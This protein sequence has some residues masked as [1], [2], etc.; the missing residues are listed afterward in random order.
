MVNTKITVDDLVVKIWDSA[1]GEGEPLISQE[2]NPD[3]SAWASREEARIWAENYVSVVLGLIAVEPVFPV[4]EEAPAE[5]P[6][7]EAPAEEAPV[8]EP[9]VVAPA[10]ETPA[11]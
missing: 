3:G 5:E 10:E 2:T 9:V 6:A 11:E 1:D 8:E 4:F 7:P